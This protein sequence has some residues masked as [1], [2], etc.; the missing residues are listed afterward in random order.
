MRIERKGPVA[1]LRLENGKANAIGPSFLERLEGLLGQIGDARAAVITGQGSAFSA[2]L[3]LPSLVDLDRATMRAYILRFSASMLRVF[4][5]PIP[6]VAAVNGHAVAGGC[7]LALQADVRIGADRD[8]RIGLNET[9]L[10][11][12]LPSAVVETLRWQVPG[13]TLAA[14]TL[15]GR[16]F[17]PREALQSGILHELVPEGELLDRSLQRASLLA[18][19]PPAGVRMVKQSLRRPAAAAA[20]AAESAEADR[21][22]DT[23]FAPE[24]RDRLRDTVARLKSRA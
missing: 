9:Q 21:W 2:G 20:R 19:L 16:L 15:E 18:A 8:A 3:D 10:G 13:P 22:L 24:S 5:L 1:L 12:G 11:I 17:S 6:L 14:L 23:W 7:V 4:E